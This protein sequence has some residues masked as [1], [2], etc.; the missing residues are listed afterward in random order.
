MVRFLLNS[1][2]YKK[3]VGAVTIAHST[4][5]GSRIAPFVETSNAKP[6]V[7]IQS[8]IQVKMIIYKYDI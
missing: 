1:Y 2:I 4:Y 3:N 6:H 5:Y 7:N 8:Y